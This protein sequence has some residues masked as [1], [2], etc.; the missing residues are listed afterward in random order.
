MVGSVVVIVSADVEWRVLR[1]ILSVQPTGKTPYGECC[2]LSMDVHGRTIQTIYV[3]GGWGKISAA[4]SAQY[5]I[6]RWSP[7]LI[8]NIGTCGGILGEIEI[9]EIVL[10]ER[11][12]VY[13]IIE[14]MFDAEEAIE[15]YAT[16]LDLS[17]LQEPY[18]HPVRRTLLLSA[19]RDGLAEQIDFLRD[20]YSATA[21]DWESGAIAWIAAKNQKRCLILRGVTDLVDGSGGEAYDGT[22]E[23]FSTRTDDIMRALME[24]LPS[25]IE[26]SA[27]AAQ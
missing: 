21:L 8:I 4:G 20:E 17:W 18:P 26:C 9:G 13:D 23:L 5:A 12:L 1:E 24:S 2:E 15:H 14:Q 16:D 19:D 7:D 22:G 27:P 10:A 11:T 3:H 6:E 25:W